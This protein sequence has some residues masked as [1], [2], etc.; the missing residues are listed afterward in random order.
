MTEEIKITKDDLKRMRDV[1][2][3][4]VD[5]ESLVDIDSVN[6]DENL[7]KE[8]RVQEYIRQIR[9]PYCYLDHGVAVKISFS[10]KGKFED[11]LVKYLGLGKENM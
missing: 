10:G 9:N 1:D 6:I 2:I 11:A 4:T 8:E 5:K 3:T 7:P